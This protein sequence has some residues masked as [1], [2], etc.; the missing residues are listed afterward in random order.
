MLVYAVAAAAAAAAAALVNGCC[1]GGCLAS[2]TLGLVTSHCAAP[3]SHSHC[4]RRL[5]GHSSASAIHVRDC[6]AYEIFS[7]AGDAADA[8]AAV[9]ADSGIAGRAV[10]DDDDDD[11]ADNDDDNDDDDDDNDEAGFGLA[12]ADDPVQNVVSK[13]PLLPNAG[14]RMRV[15]GMNETTEGASVVV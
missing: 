1:G 8:D 11:A 2:Y 7:V 10:A 4:E 3:V 6:A 5:Q 15:P 14:E 12:P 9:K 13:A